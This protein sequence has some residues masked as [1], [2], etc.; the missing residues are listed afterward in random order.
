M[1]SFKALDETPLILARLKKDHPLDRYQL[2]EL[3]AAFERLTGEYASS[4]G[5]LLFC[6]SLLI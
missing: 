3:D 6:R 2:D 4:Y 1:L 5:N